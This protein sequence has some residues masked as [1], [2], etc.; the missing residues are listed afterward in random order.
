MSEPVVV[1]GKELIEKA[2]NSFLTVFEPLFK[3]CFD[4]KSEDASL[5]SS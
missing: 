1:I 3:F 2:N 4:P 5:L